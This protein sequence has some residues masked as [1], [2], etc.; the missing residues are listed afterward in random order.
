MIAKLFDIYRKHRRKK[1]LALALQYCQQG[2]GNFWGSDFSLSGYLPLEKRTYLVLGNDNAIDG[3]FVFEHLQGTIIIGD[4]SYIGSSNFICSTTIE[5]GNRVTISWGCWFY[6]SDSHSL[7][8]E[9]RYQ[10]Y[11]MYMSNVR[12]GRG[13]VEGKNWD[14]VNKKPIK[15]CDDAWIGM[16]SIILKGVTIGQGAVVG[17]GSV[18]TKDVEPWT[19]VGGNPAKIIKRLK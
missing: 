12:N 2:Q 19:V 16:N 13:V 8:P 5:I 14:S 4:K 1:K 7:N 15:I 18:V 17:A 3:K 9:F 11:E 10:D 6:D